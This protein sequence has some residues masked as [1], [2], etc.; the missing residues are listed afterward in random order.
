[1]L[2]IPTE[3]LMDQNRFLHLFKHDFAPSS[4]ETVVEA[5]RAVDGEVL[6]E[7]LKYTKT[8]LLPADDLERLRRYLT[9]TPHRGDRRTAAQRAGGKALADLI[10]SVPNPCLLPLQM[11]HLL[12]F[13]ENRSLNPRRRPNASL[14]ERAEQM[15]H[16][17]LAQ[18]LERTARPQLAA[19]GPIDLPP[20]GVFEE[21][22]DRA[23]LPVSDRSWLLIADILPEFGFPGISARRLRNRVSDRKNGRGIYA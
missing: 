9:A 19:G 18:N 5:G 14:A 23:N 15:K 11:D 21:Q 7:L 1:M 20:F 3:R 2:W 22:P 13:L 16:D 17:M 8:D 12:A 6:L 4:V 10:R